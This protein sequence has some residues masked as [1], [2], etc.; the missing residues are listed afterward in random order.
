MDNEG[1]PTFIAIIA[2][3]VM[4]IGILVGIAAITWMMMFAANV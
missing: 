3:T 4:I 1:I 2:S